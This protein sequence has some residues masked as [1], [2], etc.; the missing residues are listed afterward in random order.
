VVHKRCNQLSRRHLGESNYKNQK[1]VDTSLISK[2]STLFLGMCI[3]YFN[4]HFYVSEM[5][6]ISRAIKILYSFHKEHCGVTGS[7]SFLQGFIF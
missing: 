4:T 5:P 2:L 7:S 6:T 1:E 3:T